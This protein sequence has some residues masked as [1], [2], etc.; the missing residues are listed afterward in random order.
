MGTVYYHRGTWNIK[1]VG[2]DGKEVTEVIGKRFAEELLRQREA[3]DFKGS[4]PK[5]LK[6][7]DYA[8]KFLDYLQTVKRNRSVDR[9]RQCLYHFLELYGNIPIHELSNR[10]IEDY[11]VMRMKEVKKNTVIL[12]LINVQQMIRRAMGEDFLKDWR[13]GKGEPFQNPFTQLAKEIMKPEDNRRKRV[14]SEEEER[15]LLVVSKQPLKDLMLVGFHTAM[16]EDEYVASNGILSPLTS[17]SLHFP[18][19]SPKA[20]KTV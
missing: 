4:A 2:Q 16:R 12:E 15:R 18:N 20:R 14:L 9:S 19:G 17:R 6:C 1:Y 11:A 13:D 7:R 10:M 8:E 3:G 5:T